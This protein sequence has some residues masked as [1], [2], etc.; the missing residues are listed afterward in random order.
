MA[1]NKSNPDIRTS[2]KG[3][4]SP[5]IPSRVYAY[6]CLCFRRSKGELKLSEKEFEAARQEY[7]GRAVPAYFRPRLE[8]KKKKDFKQET[9]RKYVRQK[10]T[11]VLD[12]TPTGLLKI[13]HRIYRAEFPW[14]ILKGEF[15]DLKKRVP[16]E[17]QRL[18]ILRKR[19]SYLPH[20]KE[21]NETLVGGLKDMPYKLAY[22][23]VADELEIKPDSL[24][25][26]LTP[27][28]RSRAGTPPW[29]ARLYQTVEGEVSPPIRFR[30]HK[31]Q[32]N[33]YS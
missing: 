10:R 22:H 32:V 33:V 20:I 8:T 21:Q 15:Q 4:P 19:Y 31:G 2:L 13:L 18:T 29:L 30:R 6:L 14:I 9:K 16:T 17:K 25:R 23:Q 3:D 12:A 5:W 26:M 27:S 24:E 7:V 1:R 28:A 11:G